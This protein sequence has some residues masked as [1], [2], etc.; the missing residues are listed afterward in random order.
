MLTRLGI[1]GQLLVAPAVILILM[2]VLGLAGRHG[3]QQAARTAR[4]S[5]AETTAVE[6]LRDSNSRQFEGHRFQELALRAGTRKDFAEMVDE[7]NEVM[8][9]SADGFREFAR[10]A[11]T[12]DLHRQALG[13][14]TIVERIQAQREKLFGLATPG[15]PLPA[16]AAPLQEAIEGNIEAA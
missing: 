10:T 11:R 15:Q 2:T 4:I 7:N 5:A 6:I 14:A 9:E 12:A 13:M 3:L 1:R 16:A 8:G